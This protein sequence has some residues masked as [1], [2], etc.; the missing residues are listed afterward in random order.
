M[1]APNSPGSDGMQKTGTAQPPNTYEELWLV[2]QVVSYHIHICSCEAS[3]GRIEWPSLYSFS[4]L[5]GYYTTL[6][7]YQ[8]CVDTKGRGP[9]SAT[10]R[11]LQ[12]NEDPKK[13]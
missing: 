6:L 1:Q 10:V 13:P 9:L 12:S 3:K 5:S 7:A 2:L 11:G 4:G 8:L